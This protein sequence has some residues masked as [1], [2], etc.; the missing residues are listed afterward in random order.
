M[1]CFLP[2]IIGAS[3]V[4]SGCAGIPI[5]IKIVNQNSYRWQ[6]SDVT[7]F[8]KN[9]VV[10]V[11]GHMKPSKSFAARKG[12]I[13]ISVFNFEGEVIMTTTATLGRRVMRR[14]GNYFTVDLP[15]ELPKDALIKVSFHN[16]YD[17]KITHTSFKLEKHPS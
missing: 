6:I 2:F 13:D 5:D 3:I 8:N 16:Q 4:I 11:S 7:A 15:E 9:G 1:K 12:Y 14:G 17:E 10:K